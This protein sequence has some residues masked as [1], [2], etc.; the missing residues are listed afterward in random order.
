MHKTNN[1]SSP[2]NVWLQPKTGTRS[3]PVRNTKQKRYFY[4]LLIFKNIQRNFFFSF[5][6][7]LWKTCQNHWL[8][9]QDMNSRKTTKQSRFI[10]HHRMISMIFSFIFRFLLKFIPIIIR[11]SDLRDQKL[12]VSCFST[13]HVKTWKLN[14][15]FFCLS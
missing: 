6:S 3:E 7:N 1:W 14:S 4:S 15:I 5:S 10:I 2:T 12:I 9:T 11:I 13:I 8:N